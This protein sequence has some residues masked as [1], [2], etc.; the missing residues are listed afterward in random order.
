[1]TRN[2]Q[3]GPINVGGCAVTDFLLTNHL[4][5]EQVPAVIERDRLIMSARPGFDRK[6][7]PLLVEPD[8]GKVY[9]GGRYLFDT[10]E[11]AVAFGNWCRNEFEIDGVKIFDRPDFS[12]VSAR[13]FRVIGAHDF[14]DVHSAQV[15]Y[16]TEI[17]H[18]DAKDTE[19]TLL[20]L[21]PA[22]RD[23][24][25]QEDKSSLW[26]LHNAEEGEIALVT[27]IDRIGQHSQSELDYETLVAV[28]AA[29]SYGDDWAW[30]EKIFDRSHWVYAVWFPNTHE[31]KA[32]P[33]LWPNSPPLP[34]AEDWMKRSSAA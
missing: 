3:I 9:S 25:E 23:R 10:C 29:R 31:A 12:E 7:L 28:Q 13:I 16:R 27:V 32:E 2:Y 17:W 19:D 4:P 15:A 33:P 6:L 26:L 8:S 34:A 22:L 24:A 14:K 18:C 11:N 30:A 21:W 1:M 20:K 5:P